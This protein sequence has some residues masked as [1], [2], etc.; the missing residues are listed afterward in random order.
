MNK[1]ANNSLDDLKLS[2]EYL[3]AGPGFSGI[4]TLSTERL[5]D[6]VLLIMDGDA[7]DNSS[8][9]II[10]MKL[11]ADAGWREACSAIVQNHAFALYTDGDT[12]GEYVWPSKIIS[13]NK[14]SLGELMI[15]WTWAGPPLSSIAEMLSQIDD[16]IIQSLLAVLVK[17]DTPQEIEIMVRKF[18]ILT[19]HNVS[20]SNIIEELASDEISESNLR[21]AFLTVARKES[22]KAMHDIQTRQKKLAPFRGE[23]QHIVTHWL[24][25][26]QSSGW[27]VAMGRGQRASA[28]QAY[29][30]NFVLKNDAMPKGIHLIEKVNYSINFEDYKNI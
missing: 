29:M 3:G 23:M 13:K 20:V 7:T 25:N 15:S 1:I 22:S 11:S 19:E 28:I 5:T 17:F 24:R 2:F 10:K 30:E 21:R 12:S 8:Y 18:E 9:N 4:A 26:Q 27:A 16:E 6:G 14:K